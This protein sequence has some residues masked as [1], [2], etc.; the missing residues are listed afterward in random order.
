M[1]PIPLLQIDAFTAEPFSGNPAAICLLRTPAPSDW[2]QSLALEMNLSETAFIEPREDGLFSL[3]WFTP[4][5]EVD[6][7]GHATLAAAHAVWD[8]DLRRGDEP[9]RFSTRSGELVCRRDGELIA[10]DLPA[11]APV[12]HG[13]VDEIT[14][15]LGQA[16]SWLGLDPQKKLIALLPNEDA[17]RQC[18]PDLRKLK[19]LPYQ[20][21]VITAPSDDDRFDFASRFFCPAVGIDEDPVCGS[22]HCAL[23]PFWAE[24]LGKSDLMGHQV[25][26][27]G[28]VLRV[29]PKGDRVELAG[30]AV[31]VLR[32]E[33]LAEY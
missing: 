2:M 31:T 20:G 30:R 13:D 23:G 21:C 28:G 19:A 24:R 4:A 1:M 17:V 3:R 7:C 33:V 15:V 18:A 11:C 26:A 29:R 25:S 10:M 16:P 8:W 12:E 22:A 32:A 6:L 5:C 9:A 27:R 14:Q